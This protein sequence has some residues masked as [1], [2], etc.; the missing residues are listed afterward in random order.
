MIY[1][2]EHCHYL[3]RASNPPEQCPDC[4]KTP[5]RAAAESEV[6]EFLRN[7]SEY[8]GMSMDRLPDYCELT[9]QQPGYF[10]FLIP[11]TAFGYQDD[12]IM[13][14]SVEYMLSEDHAVYMVNVWCR[15]KGTRS[16]QLLYGPAVPASGDA[17]ECIVSYLNQDPVF[18]QM[19]HDYIYEAAKHRCN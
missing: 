12:M 11:V 16:K 1:V 19:M 2:C 8:E 4:G 7:T 3:F 17:E 18:Q 9:I 15:S 13:E 10:K 5:I 14:V 6:Q